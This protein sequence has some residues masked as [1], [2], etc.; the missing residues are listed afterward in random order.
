MKVNLFSIGAMRAG[1]TSIYHYLDR[2]PEIFMSPVKEP[3]FFLAE[4][5]RK[6]LANEDALSKEHRQRLTNITNS[7]KY[8]T[9]KAYQSLFEGADNFEYIGEASHYLH[10]PQTAQIIHEY[11]PDSKI[12]ICL[13][14]P[15]DRFFS[16]YMLNVRN[17][18]IN[19]SFDEFLSSNVIWNVGTNSWDP[20]PVNRLHKGF[21]SKQII[22]WLKFFGDKNVKIFLFEDFAADQTEFCR[23]LYT[24]IGVDGT[25]QP[26]SIHSQASGKPVSS[27]FKKILNTD[28]A[29]KRFLKKMIHHTVR[30]KLRQYVYKLTLKRAKM[31]QKSKDILYD[32][33]EEDIN[34]LE[35]LISRDLSAWKRIAY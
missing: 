12:I 16:E 17:S 7:G 4:H 13:R 6:L 9:A 28:Y 15:I 26:I 21:Y 2:H 3:Y 5:C 30:V 29:V 34:R 20:A 25:F 23:K 8:R 14:N 31:D 33:Y 24:W 10:H 35:K 18:N 19:I 11:N 32:I 22:P 27:Q 1:S